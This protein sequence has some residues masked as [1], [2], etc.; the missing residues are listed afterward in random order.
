MDFYSR[1]FLA[2][3]GITRVS[4]EITPTGPF[5]RAPARQSPVSLA[6]PLT[7]AT[8]PRKQKIPAC[9]GDGGGLTV[10]GSRK[11]AAVRSSPPGSAAR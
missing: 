10:P 3:H 7:R 1:F 11:A 2:P 4:S 5:L 9:C 6:L 8:G